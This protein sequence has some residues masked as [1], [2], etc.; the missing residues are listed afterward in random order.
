MQRRQREY[1]EALRNMQCIEYLSYIAKESLTSKLCRTA[2]KCKISC[3]RTSVQMNTIC[4]YVL[5]TENCLLY[6]SL[7]RLSTTS[8]TFCVVQE[9]HKADVKYDCAFYMQQL[10]RCLE[11]FQ[12]CH[13]SLRPV[14]HRTL[15]GEIWRGPFQL[16]ICQLFSP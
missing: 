2:L 8:G 3:N 6:R 14:L 10:C 5:K 16:Y 9:K 15:A 11:L 1:S 13:F 12:L 7:H 4:V